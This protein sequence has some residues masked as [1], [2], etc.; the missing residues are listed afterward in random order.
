MHYK[1]TQGK[2]C[3]PTPLFEEQEC[4]ISA[5]GRGAH[6]PHPTFPTHIASQAECIN[7]LLHLGTEHENIF[8]PLSFFLF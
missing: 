4:A 1:S 8:M 3:F 6:L 7:E 2:K 5:Y